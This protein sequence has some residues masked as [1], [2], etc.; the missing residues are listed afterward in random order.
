[1]IGVFFK[2]RKRDKL[3]LP[4]KT[5]NRGKDNYKTVKQQ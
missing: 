4:L 2:N 5:S 3:H 1:M